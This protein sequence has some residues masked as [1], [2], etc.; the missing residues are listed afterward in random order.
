MKSLKAA[1]LCVLIAGAPAQAQTARAR[2][3][4]AASLR[5][6]APPP[7]GETQ[8]ALENAAV[9]VADA[10]P[11]VQFLNE[12]SRMAIAHAANEK[13][14]DFALRVARDETAIGMSM[15]HWVRVS[16]RAKPSQSADPAVAARPAVPRMEAPQAA[17]LQRLSNLQGRDFDALYLSVEKDSLQHL[18]VVYRD[19]LQY[20]SDPGLH[21][22]AAQEA[23][24]V[25]RL[26]AALGEL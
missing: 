10:F 26:I 23:A 12:T 24:E 5:A 3:D 16:D 18:D 4:S 6:D 15:V 11:D 2:T 25:K 22:V 20:G 17:I 21:A 19:F 9:L 7:T 1:L 13:I 14:R 8:A